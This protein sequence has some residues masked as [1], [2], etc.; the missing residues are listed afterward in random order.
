MP[1]GGEG[2][3][4]PV[5]EVKAATV[6][7]DNRIDGPKDNTALSI[8]VSRNDKQQ[9]PAATVLGNV[10]TTRIAATLP[11]CLRRRGRS[12]NRSGAISA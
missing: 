7:G 12:T 8:G 9:R 11:V 2:A 5:V 6:A 10:V 3:R 4:L 1:R